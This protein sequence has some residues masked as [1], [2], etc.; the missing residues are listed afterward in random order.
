MEF[1][2][3]VAFVVTYTVISLLPGP[4]VFMVISQSLRHGMRGAFACIAGDILGGFVLIGLAL[5]GV[6]AIL[7]ASATMFQFVKWAGVGYMAYLGWR[8]IVDAGAVVKVPAQGSLKAGFLTGV[9]NPKAIVFYMA[10]LAQFMDASTSLGG[11]FAV[12]VVTSSVIVGTVLTGYALLAVRARA[13]FSSDK[14]RRRFGLA[15]GGFLIGGS[16]LMAAR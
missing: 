7:A 13:M 4:S 3:W 8:Q 11:Q 1:Q 2:M 16:V 15:G 12:L 10:F 6:G 9:L 14:A 5:L